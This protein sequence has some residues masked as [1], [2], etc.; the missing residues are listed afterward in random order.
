MI[1]ELDTTASTMTSDS[2]PKY[3]NATI[4]ALRRIQGLTIVIESDGINYSQKVPYHYRTAKH[5]IEQYDTHKQ[6]SHQK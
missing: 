6:I 3:T 5:A 4:S 2:R 1:D